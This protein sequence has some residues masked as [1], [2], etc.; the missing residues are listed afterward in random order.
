MVTSMV[1]AFL[2]YAG[3]KLHI[4]GYRTHPYDPPRAGFSCNC[5]SDM[6][7]LSGPSFGPQSLISCPEDVRDLDDTTQSTHAGC[8]Q[9]RRCAAFQMSEPGDINGTHCV[10]CILRTDQQSSE[11]PLDSK[12]VDFFCARYGPQFDTHINDTKKWLFG[13][14]SVT[15]NIQHRHNATLLYQNALGTLFL[16]SRENGILQIMGAQEF[17]PLT[18][19]LSAVSFFGLTLLAFGAGFPSGVFMPT[20]M[21]GCCWGALFGLAVDQAFTF[22]KSPAPYSLLGAVAMLGG[23]QRSSLSLVVIIVEGTGKIDYLLPIILTT[24]V[25]KWLGDQLNEGLYHTALHRKGMPYLDSVIGKHM[26][27]QTVGDVMG[28]EIKTLCRVERVEQVV[29]TLASCAHHGFPVVHTN[30]YGDHV[31]HGLILRGQLLVLLMHKQFA[32]I[33]GG[34][35]SSGQVDTPVAAISDDAREVLEATARIKYTSLGQSD[36]N[37]HV[38]SDAAAADAEA[39]GAAKRNSMYRSSSSTSSGSRKSNVTGVVSELR[40]SVSALLLHI[41]GRTMVPME[42][43]LTAIDLEESEREQFLDLATYMNPAPATVQVSC[44]L[45]RCAPPL[46]WHSAIKV[47]AAFKCLRWNAFSSGHMN[48]SAPWVCV[49]YLLWTILIGVLA[50][51]ST[52]V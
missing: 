6:A 1:M 35:H 46:R 32:N 49:T 12:H 27:L 14:Q 37:G 2:I 23:V 36:E 39:L 15:Y 16:S 19:A 41:G 52:R 7:A 18:L 8:R 30:E 11:D 9:Y 25:S 33:E 38:D 22:V 43:E 42:Q 40:Q 17:D 21:I 10:Q 34:H 4:P 28:R 44:P 47:C 24:I 3:G 51:V 13:R 50:I 5:L 31:L 26:A 20:I 29:N 48:Y 45:N